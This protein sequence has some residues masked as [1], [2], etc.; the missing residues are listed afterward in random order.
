MKKK[1]ATVS[2]KRERQLQTLLGKQFKDL[3]TKDEKDEDRDLKTKPRDEM[4]YIDEY[5][6]DVLEIDSLMYIPAELDH[7]GR[8]T[9]LL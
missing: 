8:R 1:G 2:K 9:V 3:R 7:K 6:T 5:A 4:T